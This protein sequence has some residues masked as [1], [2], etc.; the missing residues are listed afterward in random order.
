M[1]LQS[2]FKRIRN[3]EAWS[4]PKSPVEKRS[5]VRLAGN[6]IRARSNRKLAMTVVMILF[7]AVTKHATAEAAEKAT[8][9]AV[10]VIRNFCLTRGEKD[11]LLIEG[12]GGGGFS[13][14]KLAS[15]G[16][17]IG[18]TIKYERTRVEGLPTEIT[19]ESGAQASEMRECMKPYIDQIIQL[20]LA[21]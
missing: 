4:Q 7:A 14:R 16:V 10:E 8:D 12:D 1:K 11:T 13:I 17:Q 9:T 19:K 6:V 5:Y 20:I 21:Q 3:L 18:A 2:S 15:T